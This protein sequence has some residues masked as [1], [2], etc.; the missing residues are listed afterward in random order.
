MTLRSMGGPDV[1]RVR[2]AVIAGILLCVLPGCGAIR[3]LSERLS[4]GRG[5]VRLSGGVFR[6]GSREAGPQGAPREVPVGP[7]RIARHEVTVKDFVMYLNAGADTSRVETPQIRVRKGCFAPARRK[8]REPVSH[9]SFDEAEA[10]CRWLSSKWGCRVR[11]PTEAEWEYAARGGIPRARYPW[12][13]GAPQGRAQFAEESA[14]RVGRYPPNLFGLYDMAGNVFE[15]CAPD[16]GA[17][18]GMAPARGGSWAERDPRLL[19]VF[20]RTWFPRDYRDADVGF[21]IVVE[22]P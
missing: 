2:V 16:D 1:K 17:P 10:Y 15:W 11:L 5:L 8:G 3:A 19:C 18:P 7:F 12:G 14:A 22:G 13:W 20:H 9:V 21:R 4:P 6:M